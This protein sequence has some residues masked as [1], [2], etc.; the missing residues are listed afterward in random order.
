MLLTRS[1]SIARSNLAVKAD[2][3]YQFS[4]S[5]HVSSD[6]QETT[7]G[8]PH[9]VPPSAH[10]FAFWMVFVANWTSDFLSAL[11]LVSQDILVAQQ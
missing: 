3:H 7:Q 11:D 4:F 9:E 10:S 2:V 5:N 8:I 6:I 1:V